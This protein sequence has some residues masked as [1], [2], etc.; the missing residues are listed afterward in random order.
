M[1]D[2]C[3]AKRPADRH[4]QD[5]HYRAHL[6][7]VHGE[8]SDALKSHLDFDADRKH[9]YAFWLMAGDSR[10]N[11][12]AHSQVHFN[13]WVQ[14]AENFLLFGP[15]GVDPS[16]A[17]VTSPR[18]ASSQGWTDYSLARSPTCTGDVNAKTN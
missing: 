5:A 13:A 8:P 9:K 1:G 14:G 15:V 4:R 12:V 16:A 18:R 11:L 10:L 17:L 3:W 6:L 7:E 2:V